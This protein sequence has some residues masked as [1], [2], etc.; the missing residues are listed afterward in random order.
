MKFNLISVVQLTSIFV[1]ILFISYLIHKGYKKKSNFFLVMFFIAQ[2]PIYIKAIIFQLNP[3]FIWKYPALFFLSQPF[4]F[5]W[6]PS[7]YLY[8]HFL[9]KKQFIFSKKIFLHYLP[10]II[11]LIFN[12]FSFVI[13]SNA[14]QLKILEKNLDVIILR[15]NI[16][17]YCVHTQLLIYLIFSLKTLYQAIKSLKEYYSSIDKLHL[18]WLRNIIYGYIV[19]CIISFFNTTIYVFQINTDFNFTLVVFSSFFIFFTLIF[20]RAIVTPEVVALE[21][22]EK[23]KTSRL[24]KSEGEVLIKRIESYMKTEKPFLNAEF[25]VKDLSEGVKANARYV[26]QVINE[27]TRKN[28]YDFVNFYRIEFAKKLIS[29][30][31]QSKI[32]EILWDSGFNSKASFNT[33]F[34]EITGKTPSE[35]KKS[36][37]EKSV[38]PGNG[39]KV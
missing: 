36:L 16:L 37:T 12:I 35:Y 18:T 6:A 29:Q 10:S 7:F 28:F 23:Y 34:K 9:T 27:Y 20:Y 1:L 24:D 15:N 2:L 25:T 30:K 8:V 19:V 4:T 26:S 39:V 14:E 3:A 17:S 38:R 31:P 32:L 33:A 11:L 22:G 21:S 5:V 13:Y